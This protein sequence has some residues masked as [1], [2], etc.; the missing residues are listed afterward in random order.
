MARAGTSYTCPQCGERS[1]HPVTCH[2]CDI[3]PVDENGNPPPPLFER[4]VLF[5]KPAE[6]ASEQDANVMGLAAAMGGFAFT[7]LARQVRELRRRRALQTRLAMPL[8]SIASVVEDG[9][10]HVQGTLE[11]LEPVA[12]PDG[13]EVAAYLLRK[14]EKAQRTDATVE[15]QLACGRW[16]VRDDSGAALVDDDFLAILPPEGTPF[17]A[18]GN[19]DVRLRAGDRVRVVGPALRRATPELPQLGHAGF[20]DAP[21]MLVFD[22]TA[23]ALLVVQPV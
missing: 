6:P 19:V 23:T 22:G 8:T 3:F 16:L 12:H 13:E 10:V 5:R 2:R 11:L 21:K 15:T 4:E 1:V 7:S 9:E 20:R 17:P 18:S 14:R